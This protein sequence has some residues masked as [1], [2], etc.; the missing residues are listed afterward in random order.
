MAFE[1]DMNQQSYMNF[2]RKLL[3]GYFVFINWFS[4][5]NKKNVNFV[6]KEKKNS[7]CT[8]ILSIILSMFHYQN[9]YFFHTIEDL[10]WRIRITTIITITIILLILQTINILTHWYTNVQKACFF[11]FENVD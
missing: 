11:T 10:L 6:V 8:W 2:M 7:S 9:I 3:S 4:I 1:N 5:I